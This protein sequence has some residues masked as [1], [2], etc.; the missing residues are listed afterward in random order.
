[1]EKLRLGQITGAVGLKG[2]VR[3]YPYTDYKE[4]FEELPHVLMGEKKHS[5][6]NVRYQKNMAILK[7]SGVNDR[8]AAE[9]CKGEFLFIDRADAPPLPEDTYYVA[10]LLGLAVIEE[11]G[12]PVGKLADVIQ[13]SAQDLYVVEDE[14][15][16]RFS[17]PAV[18]AFIRGINVEEGFIRVHLIPGLRESGV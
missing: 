5:I 3:V 2:E 18:G 6:Q 7:L 10:D 11:D 9:A 8:T 16:K 14:E 17:I 12:T 15:G 13:N 1:M 4:K